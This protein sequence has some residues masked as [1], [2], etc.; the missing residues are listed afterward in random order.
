[1]ELHNIVSTIIYIIITGCGITI[2]KKLLEFMNAKIDEAQ[3]TT[4]LVKYDQLNVVIDRVQS[5]ITTIVQSINQT[6]V[7]SLK[8]SGKFTS[9]SA[10]KAK[11]MALQKA[12]E[13]ITEEM[14]TAI[15]E[16]YGNVDEYLDA[17]VEQIVNELKKKN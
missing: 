4:Q 6:F 12:N 11:D 1:M 8:E 14:A 2:V 15:E 5:V 7:C 13:L 10:V 16:V 17:L 9:E 3:T